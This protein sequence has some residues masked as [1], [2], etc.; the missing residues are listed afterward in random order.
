[1]LTLLRF[2]IMGAATEPLAFVLLSGLTAVGLGFGIYHFVL[3]FT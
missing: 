1:M 3:L 2:L